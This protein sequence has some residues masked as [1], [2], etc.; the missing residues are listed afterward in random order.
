MVLKS[1]SMGKGVVGG[2]PHREMSSFY[3]KMEQSTNII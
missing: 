3:E 1:K 2:F